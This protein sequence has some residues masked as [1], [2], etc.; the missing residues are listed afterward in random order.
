MGQCGLYLHV[1]FCT[2][3]CGYCDFFTVTKTGHD[4][5][6]LVDVLLAELHARLALAPGPPTTIFVGGGT[7]T[8]LPAVELARLLE[9]LAGIA[10]HPA[11]LE[12][13]VEANPENVDDERAGVLARAG[14]DRISL[15]AQSFDT[16][17]LA[18]LD[19]EHTPG[20]VVSAV[21]TARLAGIGRINLDLIFGIPGQTSR[22]WQA[23]LDRATELGVEHLALYGLT[24]D[25]GTPMTR[26]LKVG[27]I[28]RCDEDLEADLYRTALQSMAAKGFEQYE[29]SNFARPH[30]RCLHNLSYWD[31]APYIGVGPSAVGYIDGVRYRNVPDLAGY[32][33]MIE[34]S[35]TAVIETERVTGELLAAETVMLQLRLVHGIDLAKFEARTG[36]DPSQVFAAAI[37]R[38]ESQG[39]LRV[40]AT[41]V[42]LTDDGR[43]V[44]DSII[45]DFM[46]DLDAH[47][48]PKRSR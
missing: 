1:P 22:S 45:T 33:R 39:L 23:S 8:V 11:C 38:F 44:A 18:V 16:R 6:A 21:E 24:Y 36:F 2:S 30:Q 14:V 43:L 10:A 48:G 17:E 40:D 28:R 9:P 35:G 34:E 15:G 46:L 19:R 41:H 12:F 13:T 27:S 29:I 5:G 20:A 32:I 3:R 25:T 47:V 7:P 4:M 37:E 42:A 26:R 31:N